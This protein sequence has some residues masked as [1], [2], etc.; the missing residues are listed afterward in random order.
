MC[1]V[2]VNIISKREIFIHVRTEIM[3]AV[4]LVKPAV[5]LLLGRWHP[6]AYN[7][8]KEGTVWNGGSAGRHCSR[9]SVVR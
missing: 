2:V 5:R 4:S 7:A 1:V 9:F 6:F 8:A 3:I